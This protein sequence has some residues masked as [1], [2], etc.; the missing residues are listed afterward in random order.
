MA[1]SD[2]SPNVDNLLIGTG[3]I[4]FLPE[5]GT[6]PTDW[7]DVGFV[8][9]MEFESTI[10]RRPY[11]SRRGSIRQQVANP[12]VS[13]AGTIRL[14]ADEWSGPNLQMAFLGA[15]TGAD[16][17]AKIDIGGLTSIKGSLVLRAMTGIGPQ[18]NFW[19]P[20]VTISPNGVIG[21]FSDDYQGL[22]LIAEVGVVDN[23]FGIVSRAAITEADT[24]FWPAP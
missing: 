15:Q 10:E 16:A 17:T 3:E 24:A 11:F 23:R 7:R 19:F 20:S 2:I 8:P 4:W 18:W 21:L 6:T 14:Q 22:P 5:G 13:Q 12:P 1:A 9:T